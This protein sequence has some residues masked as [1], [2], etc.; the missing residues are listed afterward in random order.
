MLRD[1]DADTKPP[2]RRQAEGGPSW[3]GRSQT[4][5]SAAGTGVSRP[6]HLLSYPEASRAPVFL[7]LQLLFLLLEA[8]PQTPGLCW[9]SPYLPRP[10]PQGPESRCRYYA[11][12]LKRKSRVTEVESHEL[13]IR[14]S[15]GS[16]PGCRKSPSGPSL[17]HYREDAC[18]W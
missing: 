6:S 11:L 9:G 17:L 8:S 12:L 16:R 4:C 18:V 1:A 5:P 3:R 13:D 10:S 14:W 2:R 15:A 7:L